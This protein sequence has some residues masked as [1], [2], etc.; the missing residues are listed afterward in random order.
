MDSKSYIYLD[1]NA[2]TPLCEEAV[3]AMESYVSQVGR[4]SISKRGNANSL[5]TIGRDAN[6]AV[7]QARSDVTRCLNCSRPT[8]IAFTSGATES[9]FL[10]LAGLLRAN[11]CSHIIT[12][13]LEHSAVK[14]AAKYLIDKDKLIFLKPDNSGFISEESLRQALAGTERALV[15]VG[16]ANSEIGAVQ[17]MTELTSIVHDANGLIHT[18]MTQAVGKIEV[19]LQIMGVD[20]A[21]FSSHK[22]CG[23]TGV[24]GLYVKNKTKFSSA[25]SGGGQ[26]NGLRGGTQNVAGIVGMA[27]ALKAAYKILPDETVRLQAFKEII[28]NHVLQMGSDGNLCRLTIEENENSAYLPNLVHLIL[29]GIESEVAIL[30]FDELGVCVSGGSA[31]SSHSL[32]PSPILRAINI[33]DNEALCA[34]RISFGRYT[35][36][37]D[38]EGFLNAMERV[39]RWKN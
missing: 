9:I 39:I 10:S 25:I 16:Y 23:P 31:C 37:E 21:S 24:G 34:L 2:T 38:I 35:T 1:Y 33:S 36:K 12:T 20:S 5:Y 13:Q 19:D 30:R 6:I 15:S 28:R 22:F 27:A 11:E 8:E 7:E 18:D 14:N 29:R 3:C 26:E 32:E 17:N 4:D